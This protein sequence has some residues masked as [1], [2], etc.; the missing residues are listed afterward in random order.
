M[1]LE[2]QFEAA[3]AVGPRHREDAFLRR[4][5]PDLDG[6]LG[7][8]RSGGGLETF[9]ASNPDLAKENFVEGWT[10]IVGKALKEFIENH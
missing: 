4:Q 2:R 1:L 8:C 7:L 5:Q 6:F 10:H 3:D 9:P